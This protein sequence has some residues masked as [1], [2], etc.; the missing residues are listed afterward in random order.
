MRDGWRGER[1]WVQLLGVAGGRK[2][3]GVSRRRLK[4]NAPGCRRMLLLL[5][6]LLLKL[7]LLKLLLLGVIGLRGRLTPGRYEDG[8][9][10][11]LRKRLKKLRRGQVAI[12]NWC[13]ALCVSDLLPLTLI[14]RSRAQRSGGTK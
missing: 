5:L 14:D 12:S 11:R 9:R 2:L 6:M 1:R 13:R 4:M 3:Q 8:D 7:K 10:R